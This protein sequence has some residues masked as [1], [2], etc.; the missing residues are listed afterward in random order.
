VKSLDAS[1]FGGIQ[2]FVGGLADGDDGAFASAAT[3]LVVAGSGVHRRACGCEGVR[4]ERPEDFLPALKK[5]LRSDRT[6]LINV[7]T[8]RRA[9]IPGDLVLGHR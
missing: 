5:A 9:P 6:T 2:A 7:V 4:V 3:P 8:D 1:G